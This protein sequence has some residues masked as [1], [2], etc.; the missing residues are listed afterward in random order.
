MAMGL[1]VA[2]AGVGLFGVVRDNSARL[3]A[4]E[5]A[6]RAFLKDLA[7]DKGEDACAHMT[8]TA[9]SQLAADQRK[10]SCPQAVAALVGPLN[11]TERNSL[12]S[13]YKSRFFARDGGLGHVGVRDNALGI[14]A[15][16]LSDKDG[17]WLVADI[18]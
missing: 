14:T 17:K 18:R 3:D 10:D 4:L 9:R 7:A 11:D 8:R 6:G 5:N 12:A 13:S 2:V 1:L 15:L 16:I